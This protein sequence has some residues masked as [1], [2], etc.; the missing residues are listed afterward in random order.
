MLACPALCLQRVLPVPP[1][2]LYD[3]GTHR[4][5]DAHGSAARPQRLS[6][7]AAGRGA[8]PCRLTG[9]GAVAFVRFSAPGKGAGPHRC[10]LAGASETLPMMPVNAG[11]LHTAAPA[12]EGGTRGRRSGACTACP[13]TPLHCSKLASLRACCLALHRSTV[14]TPSF[15]RWLGQTPLCGC[16]CSWM[17]SALGLPLGGQAPRQ[18]V[19]VQAQHG[20]PGQ[21]RA[22][23]AGQAPGGRDAGRQVVAAQVQ[24]CQVGQ[25]LAGAPLRRQR[26]LHRRHASPA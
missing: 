6:Q 16:L 17:G 19:A 15:C 14:R 18:T 12:S 9:V 11:G 1:R 25:A 5:H 26:T 13:A 2:K 10:R 24:G 21:A 23:A 8:Q 7:A 22:G 3:A 20:Q 4:V